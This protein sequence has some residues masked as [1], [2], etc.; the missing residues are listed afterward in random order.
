MHLNH[1]SCG[2]FDRLLAIFWEWQPPASALLLSWMVVLLAAR[3]A[4]LNFWAGAQSGMVRLQPGD[5][6][7]HNYRNIQCDCL[8]VA[9]HVLCC[10]CA[11]AGPS[12]FC[13]YARQQHFYGR[14]S[15]DGCPLPR[16]SA[17]HLR[18]GLQAAP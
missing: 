17:R 16:S 2:V 7:L 13:V 6:G 15:I 14:A 10:A 1:P 8:P 18:A 9:E 4:R 3:F 5:L 12:M 11:K